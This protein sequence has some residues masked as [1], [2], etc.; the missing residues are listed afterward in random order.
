MFQFRLLVCVAL[1]ISLSPEPMAAGHDP[2][3]NPRAF[4][5]AVYVDLAIGE[6]FRYMDRTVR[7]AAI[8]GDS[9][10][11]EVG[12]E[13]RRLRV[14]RRALPEVIGGVRVFAADNRNVKRATTDAKSPEVHGALTLD[15]LLCLSDSA[16]PLLDPQR[17]TFPISRTDGFEWTMEEDSHMFA[18]LNPERSHEGI[19][20]DLHDARG[21]KR[22]A[23][24]A[25]EAGVVRWV[26][27]SSAGGK[28]ACILLES[29]AEPG[30]WY[31]YQHMNRDMVM[32][33]AGQRVERGQPLGYIWGDWQ[34]GHLHFAVVGYGKQP[35][36]KN[37]Y[38][39]VLNV[40]P[41]LYEL[42]RGDLQPRNRV[43]TAGDF[44]FDKTYWACRNFKR[45]SRY[46]D[47]VGYGWRLDDACVAGVVEQVPGRE[48]QEPQNARLRK[49]L[50]AGTPIAAVH[51]VNHY[52]FE[53]AVEPG[54]YAVSVRV[55][56]RLARSWQRVRLEG[57]EA[58]AYALGAN[59][60]AWTP[61][62]TVAVHD[63]RLTI[64]IELKDAHSW[65]GLSQLRFA[66]RLNSRE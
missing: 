55:G 27:A 19:D 10:T 37:R 28:E 31:I 9:C 18:W 42:W 52:D 1:L 36:Y 63:G 60:F 49:T 22:H 21:K 3:A 43:W 45:L 34:W 39:C 57:S 20:I 14:A 66:R 25:I 40:F 17:F 16:K 35:E 32:V 41:Q 58:G 12:G 24:V 56:D 13:R 54:E 7:L 23:L 53:V 38:R 26:D 15:A 6:S 48:Q 64:R 4:G 5:N 44:T 8:D 65:A 51:P 46:D 29:A 62:K 30:T 2:G 61:E 47:L 11:V 50:Y 33:R 59:Q